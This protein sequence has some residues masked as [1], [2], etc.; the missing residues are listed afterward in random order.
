MYSKRA[1]KAI[2]KLNNPFKQN[3]KIAMLESCKAI[4][5]HTDFVS[6]AIAYCLT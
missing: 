2:G 6:E 3:I 4:K 1:A 5:I